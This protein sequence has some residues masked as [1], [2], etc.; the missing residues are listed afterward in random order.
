M[1]DALF[2]R[3]RQELPQLATMLVEQHLD[4]RK[5]YNADFAQHPDERR[6][7]KPQ[8]HQWG[9]L[10]HTDA[11]LRA[12]EGEVL[13]CIDA[14]GIR[15]AYDKHVQQK[16]DDKTKKELLR[17]GILYHDLGKFTV[18][19]LSRKQSGDDPSYPDFSFG[20][21]EAASESVINEHLKD[22]LIKE[23]FTVPQ[24]HY[25][26]RCAALHY[27]LA[28]IRDHVK[29]TDGYSLRFVASDEFAREANLVLLEFQDFAW[30]IGIMYLGDSYAKT[31]FRI[32]PIPMSDTDLLVHPAIPDLKRLIAAADLPASHLESVL[33][34]CVSMALVQRYFSLM[35]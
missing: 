33:H 31:S 27:E 15:A 8:W 25:I 34:L 2:D 1:H 30:E 7:H 16:I 20:S 5:P 24:I 9:I 28:K 23:G 17:V 12:F 3:L 18:R 32:E 21:H 35:K 10:T 6:H 13:E 4:L 19:H 26:G 22:R 29:N 14:W 11:F